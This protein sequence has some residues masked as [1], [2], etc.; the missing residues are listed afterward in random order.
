MLKDSIHETQGCTGIVSELCLPRLWERN[1]WSPPGSGRVLWLPAHACQPRCPQ[2]GVWRGQDQAGPPERKVGL[3]VFPFFCALLTLL[4]P[5][6]P[7]GFS[8]LDRAGSLICVSLLA[9]P[10]LLSQ[11][12]CTQCADARAHRLLLC[13]LP[14]L[15]LA[16]IS[17]K[18]CLLWPL[19]LKITFF[20]DPHH[21]QGRWF[22]LAGQN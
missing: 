10:F 1:P 4:S 14:G 18:I 19:T 2:D 15:E 21:L 11:K 8:L 12:A 6:F 13:R 9:C 5:H 7:S 20:Q 3:L 17:F 16:T 22:S